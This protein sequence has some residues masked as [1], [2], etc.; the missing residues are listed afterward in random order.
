MTDLLPFLDGQYRK[1]TR[2]GSNTLSTSWT[3]V[4]DETIPAGY[5]GIVTAMAATNSNAG[6]FDIL[7]NGKS[8]TEFGSP[9]ELTA[10][11]ADMKPFEPM[12]V[13]EGPKTLSGK[14]RASSGTPT[15]A[16]RVEILLIKR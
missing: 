1:I 13:V 10:F 6:E 11:P 9:Y 8:A 4:F 16:W 3:T 14:L 7:I 15:V 2:S 12:I 5:V